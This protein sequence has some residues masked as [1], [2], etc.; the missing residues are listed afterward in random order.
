MCTGR[1]DLSF[2]LRAFAN[3][4]DGVLV[5]GC[6]LGEC[7]YL[8]NGNHEAL[9]M[10]LICKKLL[11]HIGIDPARLRLEFVSAS[12]GSRFAEVVT[13]FTR[14]LKDMGPI[15]IDE[16]KDGSRGGLRL[17]LEAARSLIP[18]VKLVERERL[19][20]RFQ[21]EDEY[22]KFFNSDEVDRIYRETIGEELTTREILLLLRD[23]QMP[24]GE[25]SGILGL[26]PTE[27]SRHLSKSVREGLVR[28]D[29][30][31][32]SFALV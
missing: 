17:R 8:T 27:V 29:S 21:T 19:R 7:H 30:R 28:F 10:M 18:Y 5:A 22:L 32:H 2:V 9:S 13:G 1:V 14:Q 3:G 12:Q 20:V 11:N 4:T 15:G 6:W 23:K 26:S 31:E 24:T 16:S 25:I